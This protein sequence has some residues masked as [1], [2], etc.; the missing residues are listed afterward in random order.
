MAAERLTRWCVMAALA[1]A[2]LL[3]SSCFLFPA[4]EAKYEFLTKGP[5]TFLYD[6]FEQNDGT[7]STRYYYDLGSWQGTQTPR[8]VRG[9]A[10]AGEWSFSIPP[11]GYLSFTVTYPSNG[12][13]SL[14]WTSSWSVDP[15]ILIDGNQMSVSESYDSGMGFRHCILRGIEPGTHTIRVQQQWAD[16]NASL[17]DLGTYE[18]FPL[19]G[20]G[21][22][23]FQSP[24]GMVRDASGGTYVV[25][26]DHWRIVR[27]TGLGAYDWHTYGSHGTGTGQFLAPHGIALDQSGRIYVTDSSIGRLI[28]INAVGGSGWTTYAGLSAPRGAFVGTDNRIYIADSGNNRIV[29]I[30]DM[31]GAN[32]V[33]YGSSGSGTGM[34]SAPSDVALDG[35]GRI[36]IAD[37]GNNRIVRIGDMGGT[38]W[39]SLGS[40]GGG[41]SQF[42]TP[43][44]IAVDASEWV[45]IVDTGNNRVVRISDITGTGWEELGK[46]KGIGP[47][48]CPVDVA[49]DSNGSLYVTSQNANRVVRFCVP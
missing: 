22:Y 38:D 25:D 20:G 12:C 8:L 27:M 45:Y 16:G 39:V 17:D 47:L 13:L 48:D 42:S 19:V 7:N 10:I 15:M 14:K 21:I 9:Q 5:P 23:D 31:G 43:T 32:F 30:D 44:S 2:S 35:L 26:T 33:A 3:V 4:S 40:V 28:R 29:R 46:A 37:S 24:S 49:F 6:D 18:S 1:A 11:S 34:F 36:Y 41:T